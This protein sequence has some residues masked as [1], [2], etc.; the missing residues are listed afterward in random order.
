MRFRAL[1]A[2]SL[3]WYDAAIQAILLATG[4]HITTQ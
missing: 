1:G 2:G 3:Y 4:Q